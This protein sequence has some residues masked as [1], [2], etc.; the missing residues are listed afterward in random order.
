M[1][2]E[3]L[4]VI[5]YKKDWKTS[6]EYRLDAN[7]G[8]IIYIV[9]VERKRRWNTHQKTHYRGQNLPPA[10]RVLMKPWQW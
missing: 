9:C 5:E 4:A 10:A 1:K 2:S 3:R 6:T 7:V 8:N